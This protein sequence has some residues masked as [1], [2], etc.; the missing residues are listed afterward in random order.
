MKFIPPFVTL[1]TFVNVT[2]EPAVRAIAILHAYLDDCPNEA[3][4]TMLI[5]SFALLAIIQNLPPP[6]N[7]IGNESWFSTNCWLSF[8]YQSEYQ[9]S[10][11]P[12]RCFSHIR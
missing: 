5:L 6:S 11:S 10:A 2:V 3:T 1:P 9:S 12:L 7:D 8:K 4:V